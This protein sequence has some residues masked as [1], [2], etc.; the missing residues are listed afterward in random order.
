[1][2]N[3]LMI[4]AGE[5]S[6]DLHGAGLVREIKLKSP[7][8]SICGI[9]G[10]KMQTE[11]MELLYHINQMAFMGFV[12][13]IRHLPFISSVKRNLLETVNE[14]HITTVVLIDYPG[15]NLNLAR[16]LKK[17]GVNVVYYITPQVWAWGKGRI[18]KIAACVTKALVIFPFEETLFRKAGIDAEFVG[19]PLLEHIKLYNFDSREKFFSEHGLDQSKEI[20]LVLPGSRK[21]EIT[22]IFPDAIKAA[23]RLSREFGLQTVVACSENIDS[24]L[25]EDTSEEKNYTVIKGKTYELFRYSKIGIVKSGTST[26][27]A[28]IFGLPMVVVYRTNPITYF[29]G[30]LLV[31]IGNIALVNIVLGETVAP[32]LI[33]NEASADMIIKKCREILENPELLKKMKEKFSMLN[34]GLGEAGASLKAAQHILEILEN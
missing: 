11:G 10:A 17:M 19:H 4:I 12:E 20:I 29:I 13:I 32:E 24:G 1:M 18:K 22:E 33:Q 27:E 6:G 3:T 5:A 21:H 14:R 26:L 28:G 30:R 23:G 16:K 2:N 9:G 15:F 31:K 8:T 7:G 34:S 25:L